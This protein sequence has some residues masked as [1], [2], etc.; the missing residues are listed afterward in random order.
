VK[1]KLA[2]LLAFVM[3]FSMVTPVFATLPGAG[4]IIGEGETVGLPDV[5]EVLGGLLPT[6][7]NLNFTIDPFGLL[8]L[9]PGQVIDTTEAITNTVAFDIEPLF[10]AY[11]TSSVDVIMQVALS[12][13]DAAAGAPVGLIPVATEVAVTANDDANALFWMQPQT[14]VMTTD[15]AAFV[16][17]DR[18]LPVPGTTAVNAMFR[19][20]AVPHQLMVVDPVGAGNSADFEIQRL[21]IDPD[22]L[23]GTAVMLGGIFNEDGDWDGNEEVRLRAVFTMHEIHETATFAATPYVMYS[24]DVVAAGLIAGGA[25]TA[26]LIAATTPQPAITLI[27]MPYAWG[28]SVVT[29]VVGWLELHAHVPGLASIAITPAAGG[30]TTWVMPNNVNNAVGGSLWVEFPQAGTFDVVIWTA[31]ASIELTVIVS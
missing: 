24:G 13:T 22:A 16:G 15:D 26:N 12:L 4:T 31:D 27:E 9:T 18:V 6:N 2:I 30:T 28:G 7:V 8:D 19:L 21:P 29:G 14:E 17:A 20:D 5:D 3:V 11:N 25:G 10:R 23:N 1:K